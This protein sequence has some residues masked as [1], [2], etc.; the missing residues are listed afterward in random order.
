VVVLDCIG[1]VYPVIEA[2]R[3]DML[4]KGRVDLMI[5]SLLD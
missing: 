4:L 2:Q 1:D 3:D 5:S